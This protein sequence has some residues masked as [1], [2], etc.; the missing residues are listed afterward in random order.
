M[1][2][3]EL[4]EQ[5]EGK[6]RRRVNFGLLLREAMSTNSVLDGLRVSKWADIHGN[7]VDIGD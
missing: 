5:A 7:I 4:V 2:K 1:H 6:K 3:E